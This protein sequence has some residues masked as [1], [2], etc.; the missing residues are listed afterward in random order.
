ME[1]FNRCVSK[2]EYDTQRGFDKKCI[3]ANG[4]I[5]IKQVNASVIIQARFS[6]VMRL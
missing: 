1:T 6:N 4:N 5:D 2:R 3:I